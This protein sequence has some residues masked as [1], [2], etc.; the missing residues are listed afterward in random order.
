MSVFVPENT[1]ELRP[2]GSG[3][4]LVV[5]NLSGKDITLESHTEVGT[6]TTANIVPAM[7]VGSEQN[8]DEK[9]QCMLVQVESS[10][11][12]AGFQQGSIYPEDILQ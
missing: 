4:A 8:G 5:R 6:V 7:Q 12:S 9:V 10:H 1:S 3:V 11:L 2:R